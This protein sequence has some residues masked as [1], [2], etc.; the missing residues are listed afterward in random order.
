MH[1]YKQL[2]FLMN[3][4]LVLLAGPKVRLDATA[5]TSQGI[6]LQSSSFLHTHKSALSC[7]S[8]QQGGIYF[9]TNLQK[10]LHI[11]LTFPQE[12]MIQKE[13][14]KEISQ[15]L[16]QFQACWN[17]HHPVNQLLQFRC[18]H[19]KTYKQYT[20]LTCYVTIQGSEVVFTYTSSRD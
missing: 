5:D 16:I 10:T 19:L 11:L 18:Y 12:Y 7:H 1:I 20:A 17:T 9:I 15:R 6:N 4:R 8:L 3:L 13:M 14:S 2:F